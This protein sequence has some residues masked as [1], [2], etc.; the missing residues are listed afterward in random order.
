[1]NCLSVKWE[2]FFFNEQLKFLE[3]NLE[4]IGRGMVCLEVHSLPQ[5]L[6]GAFFNTFH[7]TGILIYC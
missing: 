7:G 3:D 2:N 1:M 5:I 4:Q 6:F